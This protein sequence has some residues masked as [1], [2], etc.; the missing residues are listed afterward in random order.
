M[1]TFVANR[2]VRWY[3]QVVFTV[4][5][6]CQLLGVGLCGTE[7]SFTVELEVFEVD[8]DDYSNEVCTLQTAAQSFTKADGQLVRLFLNAP[9]LL[10]P[11]KVYMVSGLIKGTESFCCEECMDMVIAGGVKVSFHRWE[12][13]NG[14][15][16]SR[17]QFPELYIRALG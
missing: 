8:T 10:Q 14:T 1:E 16:E 13:P 11:E 4:D 12:S 5:R 3:A 6:A 9:V 7:G 17:G 2:G 15:N